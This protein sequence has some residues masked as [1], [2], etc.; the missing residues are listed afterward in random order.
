M[1]R[2]D[3]IAK[4]ATDI[5]QNLPEQFEMDKIK[6]KFGINVDPTTVVLLQELERFNKAR[7]K[8]NDS[9]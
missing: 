1:S 9:T 5:Q 4:I 7:F 3:F 6:R 8:S 2:D